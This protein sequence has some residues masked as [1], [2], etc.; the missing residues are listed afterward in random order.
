MWCF[1][2]GSIRGLL[3]LHVCRRGA[4]VHHSLQSPFVSTSH[5]H[6]LPR[7]HDLPPAARQ[8]PACPRQP[9]RHA[10]R[11]VQVL[12]EV[13]GQ[14]SVFLSVSLFHTHTFLVTT[15]IDLFFYFYI[16]SP[17]KS[18][19]VPGDGIPNLAP[20]PDL[21]LAIDAGWGLVRNAHQLP[22]RPRL[23]SP[24][25]PVLHQRWGTADSRTETPPSGKHGVVDFFSGVICLGLPYFTYT[26]IFPK[27]IHTQ[28][29]PHTHLFIPGLRIVDLRF[30][31]GGYHPLLHGVHFQPRCGAV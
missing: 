3:G 11:S 1:K 22:P 8:P 20:P 5:P 14:V 17:I 9:R 27:P 21:P 12:R 23:P 28:T 25:P 26:N 24:P 4:T 15:F 29:N 30:R 16:F 31:G 6:P 10:G 7:C 18:G 13:I 19:A 2:R